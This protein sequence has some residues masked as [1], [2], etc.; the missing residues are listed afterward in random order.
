MIREV[1]QFHHT[2]LRLDKINDW[3]G[4][5]TLIEP[6]LSFRDEFS[7]GRRQFLEYHY[8]TWQRGL[9]IKKH[10]ASVGRFFQQILTDAWKRIYPE[11]RRWRTW[12]HCHCGMIRTIGESENRFAYQHP[13]FM[14]LNLRNGYTCVIGL[15]C[16]YWLWWLGHLPVLSQSDGRIKNVGRGD[17]STSKILNSIYPGCSS[18]CKMV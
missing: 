9:S 1:I 11:A 5:A 13:Y 3:L 2:T 7:Q 15:L 6:I 12:K 16:G 14:A 4:N 10:I 18:T 8:L 17:F